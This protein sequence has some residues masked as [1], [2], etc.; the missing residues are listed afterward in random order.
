MKKGTKKEVFKVT[1]SEVKILNVIKLDLDKHQNVLNS[2]TQFDVTFKTPKE[3][4]EI[5]NDLIKTEDS[6]KEPEWLSFR[7]HI[8]AWEVMTDNREIY[9]HTN[10]KSENFLRHET[11]QIFI[12]GVVKKL[13]EFMDSIR[14]GEMGMAERAGYFDYLKDCGYDKHALTEKEL[15]TNLIMIS[16]RKFPMRVLFEEFQDGFILRT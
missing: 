9:G 1:T 16:R 5:L 6:V 15:D 3:I 10:Q 2:D 7:Y 8:N 13:G 4:D 11:G 14:K 12:R